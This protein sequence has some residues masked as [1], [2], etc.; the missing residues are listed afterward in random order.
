MSERPAFDPQIQTENIAFDPAV[1]IACE[2]CGR[3]N[4]PNRLKCIYC[5]TELA[6]PI[7]DAISIKPALRKLELWE[8]GFNLIIREKMP[9][10][11]IADI[12]DLL[13]MDADDVR[14][15]TE[16][17]TPLPIAR[18]ES[19][20]EAF[21]IQQRLSQF[22]I[23]CTIVS[24]IDLAA[25]KPPVRLG[26]I[27]LFDG[28]IVLTDFNSGKPIEV[29]AS[30]F[31]LLVPGMITA[32]KV[33]SLQKKRLGGK[34][35]LIDETA[36]ASDE[37]LLDVYT[38]HDPGGY[39]IHRAGFDFSCLGK[40]KALLADENLRLL[41]ARLKDNCPNAALVNNY[42]AVRRVLDLVWNVESRKDSAGLRRAGFGKVEFGSTASTSNLNQVTKYSRFQ[43]H[44]L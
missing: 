21:I 18:V 11:G 28:R 23:G 39:R 5:G 9:Q 31:A 38:R 15:I 3:K 25:D 8:H 44:L 32:S 7:A 41:A 29:D 34:T 42:S 10:P 26:R 22:G 33:E 16:A 17:D 2:R 43:W 6:I 19:E 35:K 37:M 27:D 40:D 14:A 36:S 13:S 20:K 24:D 30:E 4:P 12:A 1:M